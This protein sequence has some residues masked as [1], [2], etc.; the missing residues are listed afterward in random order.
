MSQVPVYLPAASDPYAP[1]R[2]PAFR[3]FVASVLTMALGAQVQG[4]VVAWQLYAVTHDPLAL[5]M[6]GLAEAAP[7]I[8][9]ALYAGHVADVRDRRLVAL[10]AVFVLLVCTVAL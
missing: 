10:V 8:G 1:L 2:M 3:W 9:L 5:G 7:F 4:V 6:V